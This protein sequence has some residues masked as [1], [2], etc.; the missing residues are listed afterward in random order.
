[1]QGGGNIGHSRLGIADTA[2]MLL[3]NA[4]DA[5]AGIFGR[6]TMADVH[7]QK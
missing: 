3:G 6:G 4:D 2:E 7:E 5:L 1:V